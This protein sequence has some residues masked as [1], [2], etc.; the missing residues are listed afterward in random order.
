MALIFSEKNKMVL[1]SHNYNI[2]GL[3]SSMNIEK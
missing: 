2:D 1:R 3:N